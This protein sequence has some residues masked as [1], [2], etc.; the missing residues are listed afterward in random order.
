MK[1]LLVT[2]FLPTLFFFLSCNKINKK[3]TGISLNDSTSASGLSGDSVKL[4][5]TAGINFKVKDVEKSA[6]NISSLAREFGGMIYSQS[7]EAPEDSRNESKISPDSILVITSYTP[8]ADMI[9]KIPSEN[10]EDFMYEVADLGYFTSSSALNIDDKSIGYLENALKQKNRTET[11]AT[12]DFIKN[13]SFTNAQTLAVKDEIT[14]KQTA[15]MIIDANVKYSTV[16]LNLFQNS[17][18]RTETIAN[19]ITSDYQLP[20]AKRFSFALSDGWQ[21]FLGF[22]IALANFWM[23]ILLTIATVI[24]YK[25]G[26]RKRKIP[27]LKL[28]TE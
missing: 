21:Y 2:L 13:K 27:C 22:V 3:D 26:Q 7:F 17:V 23:F 8:R 20:F 11:L 4:V 19:Y 28:K 16:H 9:V 15:N 24:F 1:L 5:K 18:V 14:D 12:R 25:F 10:L 6:R